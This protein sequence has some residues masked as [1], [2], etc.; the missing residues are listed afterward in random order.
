MSV[1]T[2]N[3]AAGWNPSTK[4]VVWVD[5]PACGPLPSTHTYFATTCK[6][7]GPA[8]PEGIA[9]IASFDEPT[10]PALNESQLISQILA[11]DSAAFAA[12]LRPHLRLFTHGIHRILQDAQ[13]TQ[14]A[15]EEALLDIHA[16]LPNFGGRSKFS[17][18]AYHICLNEALLLRLSRMRRGKENSEDMVPR[19]AAE[20]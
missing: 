8:E 18:W 5:P 4:E 2:F 1:S 7:E 9:P 16:Q 6:A 10:V 14:D 20:Y 15:L 12:L 19:F 13:D 3:P 17:T 11:G